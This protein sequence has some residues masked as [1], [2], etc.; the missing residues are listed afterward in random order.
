MNHSLKPFF[1][2]LS[3][4]SIIT[5]AILYLLQKSNYSV[6]QT[7]LYWLLWLF[8]VLTTMAIHIVLMRVAAKDPKKF[9]MTFMGI[10]GIKLFT[11]LMVVVVYMFLRPE[12]A[13]GFT[14]IF[15][16]LY[17]LY[18]T[19]EVVQLYKQLKK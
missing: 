19:F 3:V 14:I 6:F 17:F 12:T 8:F 16:I 18:T 9:I 5:F 10:T 11:Y 4:F 1:I 15:L 7:H 13:V 2:K